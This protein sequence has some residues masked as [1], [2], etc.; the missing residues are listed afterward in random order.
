MSPR[1]QPVERTISADAAFG[2]SSTREETN[3]WLFSQLK[4]AT[5]AARILQH[6]CEGTFLVRRSGTV[7]SGYAI[8]VVV[9]G[10]IHHYRII[11][12]QVHL[13]DDPVYVL[14]L[15]ESHYFRSLSQVIETCMTTDL[16]EK[17]GVLSG[18]QL[19]RPLLPYECSNSFYA[20]PL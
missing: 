6:H 14:R 17:E 4:T 10:R 9:L 19:V 18:V 7:V 2:Q 3:P 8:S 15:K 12:R 1:R 5:G 16:L 11:R 13:V 20:E